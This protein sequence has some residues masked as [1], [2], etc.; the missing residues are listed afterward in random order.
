MSESVVLLLDGAECTPAALR[1]ACALRDISRSTLH[2]LHAA[3][4]APPPRE[5]IAQLGLDAASLRGCVI[6]DV[7]GDV[8][9]AVLALAARER[10]RAIVLC[11]TSAADDPRRSLGEHAR[12]VLAEARVPVV[13]VR[14]DAVGPEWELR[15]VL[16]PHDGT[17][18][19]SQAIRPAAQ[20]ARDAHAKLLALHVATPGKDAPRAAARRAEPGSLPVPRY[21]DQPHHEWPEWASEFLERVEAAAPLDPGQLRLFLGQGETGS[22]VLRRA[23][24]EKADL[25]VLAWHGTLDPDHAQ[26]FKALLRRAP[27]PLMIL[28]VPKRA[29]AGRA[30]SRPEASPQPR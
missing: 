12:G 6:H 16:L 20:I 3:E 19:T 30:E 17:P 8:P 28:R 1:V 5:L 2:I 7:A 24:T 22:E 21:V 4:H 15:E 23:E 9:R 10:A 13:L 18:A 25:I 11:T 14:P 26:V 27:C 29:E